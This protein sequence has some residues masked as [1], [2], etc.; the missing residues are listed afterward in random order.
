MTSPSTCAPGAAPPAR[1]SKSL[2]E[3]DGTFVARVALDAERTAEP[4]PPPPAPAPSG[5]APLE[6]RLLGPHLPGPD[7]A[8]VAGGARRHR[9]DRGA[10]PRHR[11]RLPARRRGLV[12]L[13]RR[14][15]A[16]VDRDG[17]GF[18]ARLQVAGSTGNGAAPSPLPPPPRA[19]PSS[20]PTPPA[21]P[22]ADELDLRGRASEIGLLELGQRV[23]SHQ[24]V[25]FVADH[26]PIERQVRA[27]AA[28]IGASLQLEREGGLVRG[29]VQ[30]EERIGSLPTATS[31]PAP[32][33][34]ARAADVSV[35]QQ[36]KATLLVLR[37]DFESLMASMMV[38]NASAAQG[39]AVEVYFAFW[40]VNV[41][42]APR[43]KAIARVSPLKRMMKWMMP[44]GPESQP[45]SKM[46][47]GGIGL[48]M[49]KGFMREQNVLGLSGLMREAANNDVKF[50]VCTMSM[51]I[52]GIEKTD[53]MDLPNL[54][55]GGV[56]S[57][58]GAARESALSLVF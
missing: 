30:L 15:P 18:V 29:V 14:A 21:R 1:C 4:T 33:P 6:P 49:M 2:Q 50:V 46:N 57:F 25:R 34:M 11:R 37:N 28:A 27:W 3:L 42:R 39:M 32:A 55:F 19:T 8:P 54:E 31:T 45:M 56:T 7:P 20:A 47:F 36:N 10:D 16:R 38:A 24:V 26:G 51:G 5:P 52:M 41:L 17:D 53:L 9:A 48:G 58:S 40:G 35:A 12:P 22:R 44:A 13:H 43:P 23:I